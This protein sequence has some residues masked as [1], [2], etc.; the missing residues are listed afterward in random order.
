VDDELER[1]KRDIN[2]ADFAAAWGYQLDRK[3]SSRACYVMRHADG[4]K[5]IVVT[6]EDGHDVFFS[7]RTQAGAA[8]S[9]S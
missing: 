2:L 4:D 3:E 9:T 6:G 5:I 1:F 8:S 7:A